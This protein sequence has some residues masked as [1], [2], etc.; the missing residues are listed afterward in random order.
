M[1]TFLHEERKGLYTSNR[2]KTMNQPNNQHP[3]IF[4]GINVIPSLISLFVALAIWFLP[5]P[6]GIDPRGWQLL[7]IF[8][9]VIVALIGKALP[10]GAV[11]FV[12]LT[13]LITT[14]TLTLKEAFSGFSH[15]IIWLVVAAFLLSNSFMKTGLG[16]RIAYLFVAMM[17]RKT[18]GLSYGIAATELLLAPAIPSITARAGGVIYPIV[19]AL[20]ISFDSTPEKNTQRA[21]GSFLV[22]VAYYASLITSAMFI[23]AMAANPL[24]VAILADVGQNISWGQWALAALVPGALSLLLIPYLVFKLYPPEI[25]DTPEARTTALIHLKEM[26]PLSRYEWE[27][28]IVFAGLVFLWIFGDLWEIDS[29][30]V[31]LMGVSAFLVM[32]VL[33]WDDIKQQHDAWDTLIWFSTLLMMATYLNELGVIKWMSHNI[34]FAMGG[35]PWH[36]AWP[37]LVILYFYSHYLF[38]SN[39]AH[40][41]SM[42]AALLHVGI[43][44]QVPSYLMAYS[45]AFCSSLFACITHYGT[46]SAPI[47]FGSDYVDLKTWW[48]M[49]FIISLAFL[50]IWIG[51]GAVWWKALGLW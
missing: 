36:I 2:S 26:G 20:S 17:G 43:A 33:T 6:T 10:M 8:T 16:M 45:L 49:G 44:L 18:L 5:N 9:G 47:L 39:T 32:G 42:F 23:T 48:K 12:A 15:P 30:A 27:T 11:S 29:T 51:I 25:T 34:Q 14:K 31:A 7:A 41:S 50:F 35:V 3:L 37:V 40:V 22:L 1:V 28:I 4:K 46:G 13:V 38:A 19:K 21:I 24:I